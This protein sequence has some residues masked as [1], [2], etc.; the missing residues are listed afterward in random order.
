MISVEVLQGRAAVESLADEWDVLVGN[1]FTASF[2]QSA[3]YLA[4]LD[5]FPYRNIAVITARQ[6]GRLV[7]LLPLA[8]VRTDVRGL[9]F[10]NLSPIARGNY[11][12]PIV[13]PDLAAEVLPA[14]LDAAIRHFGRYVTLAWPN[15][16]VTDPSLGVL[17]SW[18][19]SRGMPF[20]EENEV[21]PRL[22]LNGRTFEE[23]EQ[24]WTSS[25]RKDVRRQRKRL[26]SEK[27]PVSLWFPSSIEEAEPVLT[28]F[29]K[30]HDEKWLSQGFP[31]MFTP[32][33]QRHFR[34]ILHRLWDHGF[35]FS[36]VRCG[37]TDVS[38]LIGF[39]AGGWLQYYRPS[40]RPEFGVYSP[41]KIHLGL[42]VEEACRQKWTGVDFLL[43]G[44]PYK[45]A[46]ANETMEVTSVLAGGHKWTPS[47]L[48]FTRGKPWAKQRFTG[49]Y[50]R[51]KMY[52]QKTPRKDDF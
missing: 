4:W 33:L 37:G 35:H 44:Y 23:V 1:S 25:H 41:S 47:Y 26:A 18:F 49:L 17:R 5:A 48:W 42:I 9:Y 50:N 34:A 10:T 46:W 14:M 39:F 52:L 51:A 29:F 24:D 13:Q 31:G 45:Y 19:A 8:R 20:V 3:W 12:A 28:E 15:I 27:G 6:G 7:G 43:G 11:E 32:Q 16:P 21:A 30:V 2:G 40:Y 22:R 38:Y 36:T